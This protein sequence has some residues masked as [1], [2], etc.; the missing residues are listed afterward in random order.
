MCVSSAT[1]VLQQSEGDLPER[2]WQSGFVEQGS[3]CLKLSCQ[4]NWEQLGHWYTAWIAINSTFSSKPLV[5][6][7]AMHTATSIAFYCYSAVLI[8]A[9][10]LSDRFMPGRWRNHQKDGL[11]RGW[12]S[13]KR[14]KHRNRTTYRLYFGAGVQWSVIEIQFNQARCSPDMKPYFEIRDFTQ[15]HRHCAQSTLRSAQDLNVMFVER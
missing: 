10:S 5:L 13:F 4:L 2:L 11:F 6:L 15:T 9:V 14:T 1:N 3:K 12:M 8:E 7:C